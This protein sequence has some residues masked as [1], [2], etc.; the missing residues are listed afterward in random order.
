MPLKLGSNWKSCGPIYD[1]RRFMHGNTRVITMIILHD[2]SCLF[3]DITMM[4][5]TF[6]QCLFVA[7]MLTWA[8]TSP[9]KAKVP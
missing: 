7:K 4:I 1:M 3:I 5:Y 6:I 2:R 8:S 9:Q